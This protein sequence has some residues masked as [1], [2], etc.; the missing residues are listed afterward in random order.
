MTLRCSGEVKTSTHGRTAWAEMPWDSQISICLTVPASGSHRLQPGAGGDT[1]CGL[2]LLI[3]YCHKPPWSSAWFT[4]AGSPRPA[5]AKMQIASV[6][7][8]GS[9][10]T[11]YN[12]CLES[13]QAVWKLHQPLNV[14]LPFSA[15][16]PITSNFKKNRSVADWC[17]INRC[18]Y[19][20]SQCLKLH[21]NNT[22]FLKTFSFLKFLAV[23]GLYCL[24]IFL[25]LRQAGASL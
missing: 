25:E 3:C 24:R 7:G 19:G 11:T 17:N 21:F 4:A 15:W 23:L 5:K 13:S 9:I 14:Y 6:I 8:D 1:L 10:L 20:D 18:T 2:T 12:V 22:Q 16:T